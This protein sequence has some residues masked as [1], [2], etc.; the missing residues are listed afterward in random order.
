MAVKNGWAAAEKRRRPMREGVGAW[1]RRKSMTVC[2][3]RAW[4]GEER[5]GAVFEG[6]LGVEGGA[7][8]RKERFRGDEGSVEV[9]GAVERCAW[10]RGAWGAWVRVVEGE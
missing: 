3:A 9:S 2:S 4:K 8:A 1:C 6:G 7:A 5:M 10:C